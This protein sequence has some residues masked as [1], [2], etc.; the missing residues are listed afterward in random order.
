MLADEA[1]IRHASWDDVDAIVR[2]ANQGGPDGKPRR[3]LPERLPD[4]YRIAFEA[5][6]PDENNL[7][8]VAEWNQQIVGTFQMTMVTTLTAGG[9]PDA[10]LESVHVAAEHRRKGL[11]QAMMRWAIDEAK[12]R[13]CRRMQLTSDKRRTEAHAFYEN[14]GFVLSH[15]GAKLLL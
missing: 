14:L 10:L 8:M 11:G 15:E 9:Q 7:L 4:G 6:E 5:I 3:E 2:L 13:N 1:V 12:R